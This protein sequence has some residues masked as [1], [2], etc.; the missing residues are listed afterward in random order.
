MT[1]TAKAAA[2]Q[3]EAAANKAGDLASQAQTGITGVTPNVPGKVFEK[4]GAS[5]VGKIGKIGK[6][7]I[8]KAISTFSHGMEGG[9]AELNGQIDK[10]IV[11]KLWASLWLFLSPV[12]LGTVFFKFNEDWTWLDAF[13]WSVVTTTT[14]GYGDMSLSKESSRAFSFFFILLGFAFV[15]AAIGNV[16]AI[17]MERELEAKKRKVLGKSL[18][19]DMLS[20]FD[21]DGKGVDRCEFVCGMLVQLGKVSEEDLLPLLQKFDELDADGSGVLTREDLSMIR[22]QKR[23]ERQRKRKRDMLESWDA[24]LPVTPP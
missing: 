7:Q 19:Q 20:E 24:V 15:G 14:V 8:G 3:A 6:D 21:K 5:P 18:S 10:E 9:I 22:K 4:L 2:E 16:S 13:Y 17:Q 11:R 12:L 1:A 23:E